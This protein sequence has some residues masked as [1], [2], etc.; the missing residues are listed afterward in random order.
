MQSKRKFLFFISNILYVSWT[1]LIGV[2]LAIIIH[3]N[4]TYAE[5]IALHEAKTSVNKDLAYR[6]WV[7]SHGGVYVPVTKRTP[8]NPYLSHIKDR[9]FNVN[10]RKYTLMNPAYTLSQMMKDYTNLYGIKTHI[11]S[12]KLLNPK[13]KPDEWETY[14]LENVESTRKQYYELGDIDGKEYLRLM[15]PL[16]TKKSCLK[17]HAFQGYQVGDIRGGVSVSIP[18]KSLYQDAFSNS[19]LLGGLFFFIWILGIFGIRLF[20]K[21]ISDYIDEKE[22]LYEQYIYGLVNVVEKR[23]TYTAGHSQRVADYAVMIAKEMGLSEEECH[24]LRRAGMLHDIGKVAIPD[25]VFLKPTKLLQNEYALIQEH[26]SISYDMLKDITIF[27]EIKE[28]VRDHHE[29][30]DGSGYPRGLTGAETSVLAQILTLADS[31]DAMTTDR[32]YKGRKSVKEALQEISS[33]SGKQFNPKIVHAALNAL[34]NVKIE[35]KHHQNPQTLL[36]KERFSYFYKDPLTTLYNEYYLRSEIHNI[37]DYKYAAWIS[38]K[39]F[40]KYNK[41]HGWHKGDELLVHLASALQSCVFE[42]ARIYRFYGDNFLIT[43]KNE[44]DRV[45]LQKV[46]EDLLDTTQIAYTLRFAKIEDLFLGEKERLEDVLQKLF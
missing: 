45:K 32:I 5:N 9:D 37:K 22:F 15:N 19:L 34:H 42:D 44:I 18:M 13:N 3:R 33:L 2:I 28:I 31:F 4:Y 10:G 21:K 17:C 11:T 30:Y 14:A 1:L 27:D 41:K 29:H 36:E 7:A 8:P 16:V 23:D 25:S 20:Q 26:V 39:Q 12:R 35:E 40:H 46:I 38:L 43:S 24:R 6:S